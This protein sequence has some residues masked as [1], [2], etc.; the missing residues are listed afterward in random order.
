MLEKR[1]H[2]HTGVTFGEML[3]KPGA[4]ETQPTFCRG[5]P[6]S[7]S[8]RAAQSQAGTAGWGMTSAHSWATLHGPGSR[9]LRGPSRRGSVLPWCP[10]SCL[11]LEKPPSQSHHHL[12]CFLSK[13]LTP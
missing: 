1:P 7:W 10:G 12:V 3:G 5:S 4:I 6:H 8:L 9:G 11:F 13:H 2:A